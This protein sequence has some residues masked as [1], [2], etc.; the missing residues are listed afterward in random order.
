ML[1]VAEG[2]GLAAGAGGGPYGDHFSGDHPCRE[3]LTTTSDGTISADDA[4]THSKKRW[5]LSFSGIRRNLLLIMFYYTDRAIRFFKM[6]QEITTVPQ[7]LAAGP[8]T[9]GHAR[10]PWSQFARDQFGRRRHRDK[11]Q[12]RSLSCWLQRSDQ[13]DGTTF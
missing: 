4:N 6:L 8:S 12:D 13:Q 5:K 10:S 11:R 9:A 2:S 3:S 7:R 1:A